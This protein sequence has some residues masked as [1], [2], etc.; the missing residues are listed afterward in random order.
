MKVLHTARS[1]VIRPTQSVLNRDLTS[2]ALGPLWEA[3]RAKGAKKV[4]LSPETLNLTLSRSLV[5]VAYSALI[6]GPYHDPI[7]PPTA[8]IRPYGERQCPLYVR[9]TVYRASAA[10]ALHQGQPA[11]PTTDTEIIV[12]PRLSRLEPVHVSESGLETSRN[13]FGV[14]LYEK[15]ERTVRI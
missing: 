4:K 3:H 10:R 1:P 5:R 14:L 2:S 11:Q 9:N 15:M 12:L 6:A 13:V 8:S 7:W